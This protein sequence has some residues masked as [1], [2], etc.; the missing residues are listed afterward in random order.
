[1]S[2]CS[3]NLT[4]SLAQNSYFSKS[5]NITGE[6]GS[7]YN[8]SGYSGYAPIFSNWRM[9]GILGHFNLNFDPTGTLT[10]S[11]EKTGTVALPI[12]EAVFLVN[13]F[14]SNGNTE[15]YFRGYLNICPGI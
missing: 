3:S 12:T 10:L 8:L 5:L 9:S 13:L 2:Y 15:T 14:P 1:M 6:G 11:L 7:L 4:L